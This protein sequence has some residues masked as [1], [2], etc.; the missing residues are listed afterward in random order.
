MNA[1]VENIGPCRQMLKISVPWADLATEY[2]GVLN[3]VKN[4]AQVNGFRVG[5]APAALVERQYAKY[6]RRE[7]QDY[8]APRYYRQAIEDQKLSVVSVVDVREMTF[9]KG[10]AL[11]FEVVL[12]VAPEIKLPNYTKIPIQGRTPLAS[13]A[14]TEQALQRLLMRFARYEDAPADAR[15]AQ[16]DLATVDFAGVCEG[17]PVRELCG[18]QA[19]LGEGRDMMIV[20]NPAHDFLPGLSAGLEGAAPGETCEVRI[21]FPA[22]H[23]QS[24]LAGKDAL[25]TVTVK[26]LRRRKLPEMNEEFFKLL[27]IDNEEALRARVRQDL[28][29]ALDRRETDQRKDEI[30]RYL[31][32]ATDFDLP[33]TVVD[34]ERAT[35]VRAIVQDMV[36]QG[37]T[38]EQMEG[39][40]DEIM[41]QAE[42]S[43]KDRVKLQ[44]ILSR[45]ADEEKI[46][47]GEERVDQAL[48][49]LAE[50]YRMPVEQMRAELGKRG[51][52][53]R[54]R[55]DVRAGQTMDWLLDKAK[56]KLAK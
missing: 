4:V 10:Q 46:E 41:G 8:L 14:D 31:L 26:S 47:V 53:A 33:Q 35:T 36:S 1:T 37:G 13:D 19:G 29:T 54:V 25:Y 23:P 2:A 34:E 45:I 22:T 12:D 20:L 5:R 39:M 30:A 48:A 18:A 7:I 24:A 17:R 38:R 51:A 16:D 6:I 27:G 42:K 43:S 15:L 49:D 55:S 52:L 28:Q 44:Y 40:R 50:R 32:N 21:A 9:A 11:T 3:T 56:L